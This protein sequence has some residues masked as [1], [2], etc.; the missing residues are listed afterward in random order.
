MEIVMEIVMVIHLITVSYIRVISRL[1][2]SHPIWFTYI[3]QCLYPT[4]SGSCFA[5]HC[6]DHQ[7]CWGHWRPQLA[8]CKQMPWKKWN[9]I[10]FMEYPGRYTGI[11]GK[12]LARKSEYPGRNGFVFASFLLR[13]VN[14]LWSKG[15]RVTFDWNRGVAVIR[16][17]TKLRPAR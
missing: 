12:H 5:K 10:L 7:S 8:F 15:T 16:R 9:I 1:L 11:Y 13:L 3:M 14:F 6:W 4:V 17:C 2:I